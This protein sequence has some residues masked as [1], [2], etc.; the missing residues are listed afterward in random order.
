MT[1]SRIKV[2]GEASDWEEP[3]EAIV[4]AGTGAIDMEH[5]MAPLRLSLRAINEASK[6]ISPETWKKHGIVK[7]LQAAA[8]HYFA[9]LPSNELEIILL[10]SPVRYIFEFDADGP[11][12]KSVRIG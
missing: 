12:L 1:D 4:P 5:T 8:E 6:I 10:P 11:V 9:R 7:W 2:F 3:A